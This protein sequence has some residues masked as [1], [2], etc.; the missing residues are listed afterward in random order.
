MVSGRQRAGSAG[1][2][3]AS[4]AEPISFVAAVKLLALDSD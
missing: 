1:V 2:H 3:F 4:L